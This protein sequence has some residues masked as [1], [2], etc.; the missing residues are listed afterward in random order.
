MVRGYLLTRER[1]GS[2]IYLLFSFTANWTSI[3]TEVTSNY[4][5]LPPHHLRCMD[6]K[7]ADYAFESMMQPQS[8][9]NGQGVRL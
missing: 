7:T 1:D 5:A 8:L 3:N 2:E 6:L 4:S 9:T